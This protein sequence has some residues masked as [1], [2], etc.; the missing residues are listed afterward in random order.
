MN[1]FKNR[2]YRRPLRL[3]AWLLILG[4]ML[5]LT[6]GC[7]PRATSDDPV[8]IAVRNDEPSEVRAYLR[9]G[10]DPNLKSRDGDPLLYIAAGPLGG[11]RV[12]K[13]LIEAG[14]DVNAKS[15]NGRTAFENAVGWCDLETI[16]LLV[17]AGANTD[18]SKTDHEALNATC[19]G[20]NG[21]R[22]TKSQ[23]ISEAVSRKK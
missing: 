21:Q 4:L 10:G 12:A 17:E 2:A 23:M 14:A 16:A 9:D 3:L 6:T 1:V 13:L 19:V 11:H 18:M 22:K 5:P 8:V 20:P 7:L 15:R